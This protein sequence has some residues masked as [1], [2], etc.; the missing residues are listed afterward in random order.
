M[1]AAAMSSGGPG[2]ADPAS[3][4]RGV[5]HEYGQGG[6]FARPWQIPT[7]AIPMSAMFAAI[8]SELLGSRR[9]RSGK[10]AIRDGQQGAAPAAAR[11]FR[12]REALALKVS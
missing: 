12:L 7:G 5:P 3:P 9:L 2:V 10:I 11:D 4:P 6:G 8:A 1:V